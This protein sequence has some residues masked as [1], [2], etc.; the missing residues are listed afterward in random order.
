MLNLTLPFFLEKVSIHFEHY[1]ET[2]EDIPKVYEDVDELVKCG[3]YSLYHLHYRL[4]CVHG[5][6]TP[7]TFVYTNNA[8]LKFKLSHWAL[9]SITN[10]GQLCQALIYPSKSQIW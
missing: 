9:N 4:G 6:I 10:C 3:L 8:N 1:T 5:L 7:E 2:I